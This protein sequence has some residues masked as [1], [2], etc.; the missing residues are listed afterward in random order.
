MLYFMLRKAA[1][2]RCVS[3]NPRGFLQD[4]RLTLRKMAMASMKLHCS[5]EL[6]LGPFC[7]AWV[8]GF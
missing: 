3:K 1:S 6:G 7:P 2:P 5:L 8:G 4:W